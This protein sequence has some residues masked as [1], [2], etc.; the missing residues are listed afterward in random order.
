MAE[1][2]REQ[3]LGV[4]AGQGEFVGVADAGG[5]DLDQNLAGARPFEF[6]LR[7]VERLASLPCYCCASP[8]TCVPP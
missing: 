7:H 4:G 1:D 5:L 3:A 6:D 8:H 2:R